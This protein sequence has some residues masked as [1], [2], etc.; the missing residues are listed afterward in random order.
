MKVAEERDSVH[1]HNLGEI[2]FHLT[3][4]W[5][6][7]SARSVLHGAS[8]SYRL[9]NDRSHCGHVFA[10]ACIREQGFIGF[11]L[12]TLLSS[13]PFPQICTFSHLPMRQLH[14]GNSFG[15]NG[16]REVASRGPLR[17]LFA[18]RQRVFSDNYMVPPAA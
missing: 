4:E 15:S 1:I 14:H 6:G 11:I 2:Q 5:K 10:E 3:I 17:V 12:A 9:S 7:H 18:L 8:E 16:P 13:N